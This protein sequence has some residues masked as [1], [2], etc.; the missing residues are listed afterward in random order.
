MPRIFMGALLTAVLL[1][2]PVA[3]QTIGTVDLD[4]M[5]GESAA[6]LPQALETY[7]QLADA[8]VAGKLGL[9]SPAALTDARS[10]PAFVEFTLGIDA[11]RS[12]QA[13]ERPLSMIGFTGRVIHPLDT[14]GGAATSVTIAR[15][16]GRWRSVSFGSP[17]STR[18]F[19]SARTAFLEREGGS[20]DDIFLLRVPAFNIAFVA[21]LR[22]G[23]L[24]LGSA[25]AHLELGI[26]RGRSYDAIDL[27]GRLA[28]PA[29]ARGAGPG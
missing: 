14:G 2:A 23:G 19:L 8:Q 20:M 18:A 29:R 10:L 24:R 11:L 12:G 5:R 1:A 27:F 28:A 13:V 22:G 26:E 21:A 7:A 16:E 3:S 15:G 4:R 17:A 25:F 9:R 6:A